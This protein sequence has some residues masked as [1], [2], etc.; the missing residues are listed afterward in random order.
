MEL[1]REGWWNGTD[2]PDAISFRAHTA[3]AMPGGEYP[4]VGCA[5]CHLDFTAALDAEHWL[6][7]T[8]AVSEVVPGTVDPAFAWEAGS[9]S[10]SY[11]HSDGHRADGDVVDDGEA[12]SCDSCHATSDAA[13]MSGLHAVHLAF[14]D[15]SSCDDCHASTMNG[16]TVVVPELHVDG[17]IDV[18]LGPSGIS[19]SGGTCS[20]SCHGYDH[21]GSGWGHPQGYEEP[22]G[23]GW[24]AN[25]QASNCGSCHGEDGSGGLAQGCDDCHADAGHGDW[26][27]DCTFCHGGEN[28]DV[29]GMPPEDIDDETDPTQ[30]SFQGHPSHADPGGVGHPAYGCETCHVVPDLALSLDHTI[31]A[32]PGVSE[33]VFDGLATGSI[34]TPGSCSDVYCHG[35]G[36]VLGAIDDGSPPLTCDG[37]HDTSA[38]WNNLSDAHPEHLEVAGITCADCHS[39]VVD[40]GGVVT[41]PAR[42]VDGVLDIDLAATTWDPGSQSCTVSCHGFDH[43]EMGWAGGH[44][45][46]YDDPEA[47]GT[48]SLLG[49]SVCNT[50]HGA[51]LQGGSSGEGCDDCH[52]DEGHADWRTDCTFCHGGQNGD[53]AGLPPEDLDNQ[54][55]EDQITFRSHPEHDEANGHPTYG[56]GTCHD[57]DGYSDALTDAGHGFD[58]TPGVAEVD[59]AGAMVPGG[60]YASG[61][62]SGVYC[63]GDGQVPGDAVDSAAGLDCDACH[64]TTAPYL[65]M[66][67][68]HALHM[69][70]GVTCSE[71]HDPVVNAANAI[72]Q[73]ALHVN[74][75]IDVDL[76]ATGYNPGAETC[77]VVCHSHDHSGMGWEG[78]HPPGYDAPEE[79][80]TDSLLGASDCMSCHGADLQGGTSGEGCDDCHA[81]EGHADWRTDCTFCHGGQSGDSEGLPPEDID[82]ETNE[83]AISFLSHPEHGESTLHPSYGCVNCHTSS[84]Y[85]DA[86][87][88]VGHWFDATPGVSEVSFA[89]AVQ[90]GGSYSGTT[91][92][93][94]YCHGDGRGD[95][96]V[97][98]GTTGFACDDCHADEGSNGDDWDNMSGEHKKHLE[99]GY[100]CEECHASVV[101]GGQNLIGAQ[102]HVDGEPTVV[103]LPSSGITWNGSTCS[104]GRCHGSGEDHN[105][106]GW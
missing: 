27:T 71:C 103:P 15:P 28:G 93:N 29:D 65:G 87:L 74:G 78:G 105:N 3:H 94:I 37:C 89:G 48:D 73:D 10:G 51:D 12:M 76:V 92:S 22:E 70:E 36:Q 44:P 56:C 32:T 99:E 49:A 11:C 68:S 45:P 57:S 34:Y 59:F 58:G 60:S 86:L 101:D 91:C 50:C 26:R 62:C 33:V 95:G 96:T 31:D 98:D 38:P 16:D 7:D 25:M 23:H 72:L 39:P 35:N 54:T 80:G 67:G 40:A 6:D 52:T 2:D 20:G 85:S 18:Q 42:H 55:N 43:D 53:T 14:S 63:H 69:N 81:D 82:N 104:G 64:S 5:E 100:A 61:S 102:W 47:H 83:A 4:E 21:D 17:T 88:D 1:L 106:L 66:S 97:S 77:T 24:D 19:W 46:G 75:D 90:S 79:H 30:I 9:C 8:P 13:A 41:R 84:G